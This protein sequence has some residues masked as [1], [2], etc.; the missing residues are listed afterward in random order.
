MALEMKRRLTQVQF[1]HLATILKDMTI[2]SSWDRKALGKELAKHIEGMDGLDNGSVGRLL[3]ATGRELV[4]P[5]DGH[6]ARR[7]QDLEKQV[8]FMSAQIAG[9]Q[10]RWEELSAKWPTTS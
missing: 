4:S 6:M 2:D 3:E 5:G 8:E 9:L 7:V 1:F 10:K